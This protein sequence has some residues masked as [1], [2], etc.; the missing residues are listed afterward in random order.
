M[1]RLPWLAL[2]TE[3][4]DVIPRTPAACFLFSS[5]QKVGRMHLSLGNVRAHLISPMKPLEWI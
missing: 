4:K 5:N 2:M 3:I 1:E